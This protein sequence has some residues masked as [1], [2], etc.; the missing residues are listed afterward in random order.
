[1]TDQPTYGFQRPGGDIVTLLDLTPRDMQDSEYTPLG[2]EKTWWLPDEDRRI[3]PFS[4]G[5]QTFPFRGPAAFGQR[6]TFNVGSV[7]CGDILMS[8]LIQINLG[9]WFDDTT[10]LRFESGRYSYPQVNGTLDPSSN[11]WFYASSL[12]SVILARAELEIDDQTLEVV[13]GDFL[14]MI[15]LLYQDVNSQFGFSADGLGR[16]PLPTLQQSNPNRPFPTENGV[17]FVPLP[18]F[19]QRVKLQEGF[20]LL[21]CREGTVRI[22]ITLRPFEECV[23][24]LRGRRTCLTDTPLNQQVTLW[25]RTQAFQM[26]IQVQTSIAVPQFKQIKLITYGAHTDGVMRQRILRSPFE[27]LTRRV[28]TF[29][30]EEPLKYQTNKS[31]NDIVQVQLPLEVNGPM[32]EILWF[33]RRTATHNNNEWNNYSAVT[34][35]EY[36]AIYN[37]FRPMLT[38]ATIQLNGVDLV[39]EGEL[40][41]RQHIAQIHKGGAA[42]FQNFVY[43]YSFSQ[44]PGE[45]QP[46]GTANASRLQSVRLTLDVKQPISQYETGWEVKVFVIGLDWLRF[47]DGIANRMFSD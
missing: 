5:V 34:S 31:Q 13:D 42:A 46:S 27:L 17:I 22:H 14:N 24:L 25:D 16:Q 6:F 40:W 15:S 20:P 8:T 30:F 44:H 43:G 47:Q 26:P 10:I 2:A 12:G 7:N 36:N 1:M 19:Y 38:V 32:E 3:R 28:Q 45:H 21:A 9:H 4:T 29:Y 41:F 35:P 18:F 37:P 11:P 39:Q 23:R 33:I